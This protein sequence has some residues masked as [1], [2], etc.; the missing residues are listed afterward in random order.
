MHNAVFCSIANQS[1]IVLAKC[2]SLLCLAPFRAK[3]MLAQ[4]LQ[5][6][7]SRYGCW[8]HF[9]GFFY[10]LLFNL[11][12][13]KQHLHD[14]SFSV[15]WSGSEKTKK[16]RGDFWLLF[17]G[18]FCLVFVSGFGAGRLRTAANKRWLCRSGIVSSNRTAPLGELGSFTIA[19]ARM[20]LNFLSRASHIRG[21][22]DHERAPL[23]S[24]NSLLFS[25]TIGGRCND[26]MTVTR[27]V[28]QIEQPGLILADQPK[29]KHG[30][31]SD[32]GPPVHGQSH[33]LSCNRVSE[34]DFL[35]SCGK[36]T[37]VILWRSVHL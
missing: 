10:H 16:T 22:V 17:C 23:R 11:F 8:V 26:C 2:T 35:W 18:C 20:L 5:V 34:V 4:L 13:Q 7:C 19:F 6:S 28:K 30:V 32:C 36:I 37:S 9:L 15:S 31:V 25:I 21:I 12:K 3:F 33:I 27:G 14:F 24:F 1:H 29:S